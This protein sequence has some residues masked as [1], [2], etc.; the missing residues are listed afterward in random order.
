MTADQPVIPTFTRESCNYNKV[1]FNMYH[2]A[3]SKR[4]FTKYIHIWYVFVLTCIIKHFPKESSLNTS[5]YGIYLCC[6][7]FYNIIPGLTPPS[8]KC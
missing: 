7:I 1:L 6:D 4:E 2:Q 3:L 5:I 8:S